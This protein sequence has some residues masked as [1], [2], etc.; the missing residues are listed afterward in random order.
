MA[1][2]DM[3]S[4]VVPTDADIDR[5]VVSM[6][7]TRYSAEDE[8]KLARIAIGEQRGVYNPTADE[9][10]M[11]DDYQLH[12]MWCR[13]QGEQA[14][15][16]A[17]LLREAIAWERARERLSRPRLADGVPA[18]TAYEETGTYVV[19]EATGELVP[20]LQP[21]EL[22][23]VPAIPPDDPAAI[24]DD[25]ERAQAQAVLDAATQQVLDLVAQRD[26]WRSSAGG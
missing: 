13:E 6:I 5:R 14:K 12:V 25:E 9:Q 16:D 18:R 10:A 22:S 21:V 15:Q 1:I 17:N 11:I 4:D 24:R 26:Q 8:M 20:E 3:M 2:V 7:R 23:G 19:D